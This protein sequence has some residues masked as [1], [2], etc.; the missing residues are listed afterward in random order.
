MLLML[1]RA[2]VDARLAWGEP[3]DVASMSANSNI[4]LEAHARDTYTGAARGRTMA[5]PDR[6]R[7]AVGAHRIRTHIG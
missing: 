3:G 2:V 1:L 6:S 7:S 5:G 4:R